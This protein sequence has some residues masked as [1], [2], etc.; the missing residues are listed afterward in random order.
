[1]KKIDGIIFDVDGTIWDTT[2]VV[3]QAWNDAIDATFFSKTSH[4][5]GTEL[6]KQ[7]GKT[8]D[9]IAQNLFPDLSKEEQKVLMKKCCEEEQKHLGKTSENLTYNGIVEAIQQLSKKYPI[10]IVSN[11][12]AGYIPVV[13]KKNKLAEYITD[14]ECF[15][16]T[17]LEKDENIK[18]LAQRNN[19]QNPVYVGDTQGD[20]LACKKAGV[21]FVWAKYGFGHV[22]E[23]DCYATINSPLDLLEIL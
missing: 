2:E 11:C 3:A 18:L 12:Q 20:L 4:V 16:A 23:E 6:K 8:M 13:L 22:K 1:M 10:F 15:G 9:V 21:L 5:T 7:F 19:L 17:G 14:T